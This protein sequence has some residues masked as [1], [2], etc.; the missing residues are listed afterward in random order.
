LT[1]GGRSAPPSPE[2]PPPPEQV[3][4]DERLVRAAVA[5]E[6]GDVWEIRDIVA[7]SQSDLAGPLDLDAVSPSGVN[8]L[9]YGIARR[10][11]RAVRA[12][13]EAGAS[14]NHLTSGGASPMLAA[15]I[16]DDLHLLRVLI[17][18]GG[19]PNL[20]NAAGEPLLLQVIT[21]MRMDALELLL[22]HGADINTIDSFGQTA[23]LKLAR[24]NQYEEVH[25][26]LL[27]GADPDHA[28]VTRTTT[29]TVAARP[30]D[31]PNSPAEAWRR[32]VVERLKSEGG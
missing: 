13:L 15:A 9:I 18:G 4:S 10:S 1:T 12:L 20:K 5:A 31:L 19:D 17:E 14:P 24:L 11:E 3:F 28:D 27:R 26:L 30:L 16:S 29:R 6:R 2:R 25:R 32:R 23:V 21:F 22:D 8:L 7:R